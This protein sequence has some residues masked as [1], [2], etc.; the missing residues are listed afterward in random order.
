MIHDKIWGSELWVSI[1]KFGVDPRARH[2]EDM[3]F[4]GV[5]RKR[6]LFGSFT[7]QV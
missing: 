4:P 1:V 3:S 5:F 2:S 7:S 6:G